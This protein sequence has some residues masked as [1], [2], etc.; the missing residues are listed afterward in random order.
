MVLELF[1]LENCIF[2]DTIGSEI[3]YFRGGLWLYMAHLI[4]GSVNSL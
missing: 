2:G 4:K 1:F 3:F